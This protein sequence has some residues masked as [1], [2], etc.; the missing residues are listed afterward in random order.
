MRHSSRSVAWL[1]LLQGENPTAEDMAIDKSATD[2]SSVCSFCAFCWIIA[3]CKTHFLCIVAWSWKMLNW[4]IEKS[5]VCRC[6]N[7][8][9]K[10]QCQSHARTKCMAWFSCLLALVLA[11]S[12]ERA[13]PCIWCTLKTKNLVNN[14][15][16]NQF[17]C[18]KWMR[19]RQMN[20]KSEFVVFRFFC[21]HRWEK[22]HCFSFSPLVWQPS[23]LPVVAKIH[24]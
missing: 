23:F 22:D 20:F 13:T 21:P 15:L 4:M 17:Q 16:R 3:F 19:E 1:W 5:L 12:R 10:I 2:L 8:E 7:A 6:W 24:F 18:G 14:G 9:L 11:S